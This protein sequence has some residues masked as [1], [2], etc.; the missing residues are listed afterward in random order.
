MD[1]Q[2]LCGS[3]H[4]AADF[5]ALATNINVLILTDIPRIKLE[6]RNEARRFITLIDTLYENKVKLIV[7]AESPIKDLLSGEIGKSTIDDSDR[8]LID[9]LKL[10]SAHVR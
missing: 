8:M 5:L 1:F 6:H 7:S 3:P 4:S 9:D 2:E 10:N